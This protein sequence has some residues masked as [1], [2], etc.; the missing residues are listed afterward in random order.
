[1]PGNESSY[2]PGYGWIVESY[3]SA[4]ER[5]SLF[6]FFYDMIDEEEDLRSISLLWPL[7]DWAGAVYE[8]T[9]YGFSQVSEGETMAFEGFWAGADF[10]KTDD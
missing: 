4:M 1:L 9:H 2:Y 10:I 7:L 5:K 3:I 6:G 8:R